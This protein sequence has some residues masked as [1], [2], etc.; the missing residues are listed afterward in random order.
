VVSEQVA[1]MLTLLDERALLELPLASRSMHDV[2]TA[3]AACL[4]RRLLDHTKQTGI[5]ATVVATS[6][7]C[8]CLSA[9]EE[10][11]VL[12]FL[13]KSRHESLPDALRDAANTNNCALLRLLL[14]T[15]ADPNAAADSGAH[16][17]GFT[18]VGAYPLH[19]AAKRG[20]LS[21]LGVLLQAGANVDAADQNGRTG[22]M[23]ASASGQAATA[24]ELLRQRASVNSRSH[25][26]F[27]PLHHA[28]QLPFFE[29]ADLLLQA[30]SSTNIVNLQDQTPLHIVLNLLS[31]RSPTEL[32]SCC[33]PS[34][35]GDEHCYLKDVSSYGF[36]NGTATQHVK[37]D[38][39]VLKTAEALLYFGGAG[40]SHMRDCQGRSARDILKQKHR[41]E[42]LG[43]LEKAEG[44]NTNSTKAG[45]QCIA[46]LPLLCSSPLDCVSTRLLNRQ[47]DS[48]V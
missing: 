37:R 47:R 39:D 40:S 20:H 29:L 1:E 31:Q 19:V 44:K 24:S 32:D 13:E 33:D 11:R 46:W 3:R 34:G 16:G 9:K 23:V 17:V 14:R 28:V 2:V 10:F 22:L 6:D 15:R 7:N 41:H 18:Q 21:A 12:R 4:W 8:K 25:Y 42:L 35:F 30:G 26:G 43:W 38:G 48:G 36:R 45:R 27:T 5:G